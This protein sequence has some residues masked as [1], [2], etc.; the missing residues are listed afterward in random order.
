[1]AGLFEKIDEILQGFM[2]GIFEA[3]N[4]MWQN[5]YTHA[6]QGAYI[7]TLLLM[8]FLGILLLIGLIKL[9]KK[10]KFLIILVV[11]TIVI[12]VLWFIFVLPSL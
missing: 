4:S 3:I 5:L 9:I 7:V 11:L 12:P 8:V 2:Q 6:G 1:M 10:F